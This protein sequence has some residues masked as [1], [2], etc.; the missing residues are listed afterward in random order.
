MDLTIIRGRRKELRLTQ[1]DLADLAGVSVRFLRELEQGK[2]SVQLNSVI[3]VIDALGLE[4]NI[5]VRTPMARP[6]AAR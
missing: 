5:A 1:Q 4:V 6:E 3:A 2:E